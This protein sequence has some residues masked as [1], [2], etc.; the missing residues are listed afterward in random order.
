LGG[1][2]VFAIIFTGADT[3]RTTGLGRSACFALIKVLAPSRRV[4]RCDILFKFEPGRIPAIVLRTGISREVD[5]RALAGTLLLV[6]PEGRPA[7]LSDLPFCNGMIKFN[8]RT[9]I[10]DSH[11][12]DFNI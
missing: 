7:F 5:G 3:G 2:G 4:V 8:P 11:G 1:A 12:G 10:R 9:E 6:T